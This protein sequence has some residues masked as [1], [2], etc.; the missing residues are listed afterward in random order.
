MEHV[1]RV[2]VQ[3][4]NGMSFVHWNS[5]EVDTFVEF[6]LIFCYFELEKTSVH[7]TKQIEWG[8]P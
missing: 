3:K 1:A 6:L 4:E 5:S 2:R 7:S 8:V